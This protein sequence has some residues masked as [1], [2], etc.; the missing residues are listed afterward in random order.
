MLF[1]K[2][3]CVFLPA[4]FLDASFIILSVFI[5]NIYVCNNSTTKS[6]KIRTPRRKETYKYLGILEVNNIKQAEKKEE[7]KKKKNI[8][9]EWK[10]KLL[11]TKL[12]CRDVIKN[13]DAWAS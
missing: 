13:M 1:K 9:R 8:S 11:E 12:H 3:S 10:E 7:E 4:S 2:S 5:Q 6:R